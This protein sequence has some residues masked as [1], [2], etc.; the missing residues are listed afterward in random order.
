MSAIAATS[1]ASTKR[2]ITAP[3]TAAPAKGGDASAGTG[4]VADVIA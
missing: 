3:N 4:S 1:T 2:Y